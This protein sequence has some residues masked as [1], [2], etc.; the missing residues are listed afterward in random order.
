MQDD[1]WVLRMV[2][3]WDK[4]TTGEPDPT[5]DRTKLNYEWVLVFAK[6]RSYYWNQDAIREPLARN[7]TTRGREI[8]SV[9]RRDTNRDFRSKSNPNGRIAGSVLRFNSDS[10]PGAHAATLPEDLAQWILLAMCDDDAVVC[11]IF[12]GAG[13]FAMVALQM[14][15]SA[16]TIDIFDRY[17]KEA[18]RRLSNAPSQP[19][20]L[21]KRAEY[22]DTEQLERIRQLEAERDDL[23]RRLEQ[24]TGR[25]SVEVETAQIEVGGDERRTI[26]P[27]KMVRRIRGDEE[28]LL[29]RHDERV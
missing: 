29:A 7:H 18:I 15:Y 19:K 14:G 13:T 8:P 17:T 9:M 16:I 28:P 10:Y 22:G 20:P 24:L 5:T 25:Q 11:D 26:R 3:P 1:G 6:Q 4:G 12:G 21:P 27:K 23:R 2:L